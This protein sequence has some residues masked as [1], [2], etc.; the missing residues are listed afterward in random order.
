M[1][2][3]SLS[4]MAEIYDIFQYFAEHASISQIVASPEAIKG[5]LG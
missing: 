5:L 3:F 1:S 2:N 4:K